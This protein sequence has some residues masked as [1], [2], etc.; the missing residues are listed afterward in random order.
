MA[1]QTSASQTSDK[2]MDHDRTRRS[3]H[4]VVAA[5]LGVV[6]FTLV[7]IATDPPGPG[8]DPD[9]MA[10]MGAAESLASHARYRV[11]GADWWNPDSTAAL[12]HFPPGYS[13]AL[14]L[15][16]RLGMAPPQAAR[17]VDAGAAA[18]TITAVVLLVAEAGGLVAGVLGALA[19][20][21]MPAMALVHLSVLSE[22]LFLACTMLTLAAMTRPRP[23][24]LAAGIAAAAGTLVRY[25]GVSL[26]GAGALW[27]AA[28][29]GTPRQRVR[30]AALALLPTVLLQGAWVLRTKI[31]ALREPAQIRKVAVYGHFDRTLVQGGATLRDWLMPDPHPWFEPMPYRPLL[32][33]AA[34]LVVT[35]LL[36][37]GARRALAMARTHA[38]DAGTTTAPARLLAACALLTV[39]YLGLLVVSR[40]FADPRIPFDERILAPFF[41]LAIVAI[42]TVIALRWRSG[43]RLLPRIVLAV[44]LAGWAVMSAWTTSGQMRYVF[45]WGS[46]F[47]GEQW[48][49]SELLAWARTD[50]AP[51]PLYTNWPSAVY[52]HLHRPARYVPESTDTLRLAAFADTLRA[53]DGRALLFT[54]PAGDYMTG[55]RLARV[56]GLEVIEELKDGIVLQAREP[57][58]PR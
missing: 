53:H 26:A 28:R 22:P 35:A 8:L 15:P 50:G 6:A 57:A 23:R 40:L 14:A 11:P 25:A 48:R 24:P 1:P 54:V 33:L 39:C 37:A 16:V 18:V 32:A 46:D 2:R 5:I 9:A 3:V 55:D 56:P 17:L 51:H 43:V 31:I 58:P 47:A 52:F 21:V 27:M 38:S 44:A 12:T 45:T 7:L 20:F 36:V 29:P 34:A 19:L 49:R 30:R 4:L 13:T 10:Y 42:S 41:L